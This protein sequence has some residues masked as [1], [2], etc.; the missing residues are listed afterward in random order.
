MDMESLVT[1]SFFEVLVARGCDKPR[2]K[3]DESF[4][5][6]MRETVFRG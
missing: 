2:R 3:T 1:E 6:C 4:G 5:A